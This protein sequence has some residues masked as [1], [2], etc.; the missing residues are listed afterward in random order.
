[1]L[2]KSIRDWGCWCVTTR[3]IVQSDFYTSSDSVYVNAIPPIIARP[4]TLCRVIIG[5]QCLSSQYFVII[6]IGTGQQISALEPIVIER[7]NRE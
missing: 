7:L 3:R 1:M 6:G 4:V 5:C 2:A